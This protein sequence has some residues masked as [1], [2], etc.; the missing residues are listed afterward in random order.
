MNRNA[1][2]HMIICTLFAA[3][4][5]DDA[6]ETNDIAPGDTAD[7]GPEGDSESGAVPET[8]QATIAYDGYED[9]Y[10][11]TNSDDPADVCRVRYPLTAVADPSIP[12][13]FCEWSVVVEK[14]DPEVVLDEHG[15]CANSDLSLTEAEMAAAVG[16]RIA[17]GFAR[18]Y[19]GHTSILMRYN[20]DAGQWGGSATANWDPE[21]GELSYDHRDGVC[22]YVGDTE[23]S[24]SGICGLSGAATVSICKNP[25][26]G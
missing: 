9:L 3:S 5:C 17:Y 25:H 16:E 23:P 12:C 18:E 1:L 20:E 26:P 6:D 24:T 15:A 11:L 21:T 7:A 10:I 4:G 22:S 13:D 8:S 2:L 19:V 14:G